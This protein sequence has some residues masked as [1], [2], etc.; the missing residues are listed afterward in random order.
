MGRLAA[1]SLAL[2]GH[3]VY[4]SMRGVGTRNRDKA[5]EMT[6]FARDNGVDLQPLELDVLSTESAQAA[7]RVVESEQARV[8]AL[9]NNAAHLYFGITDAFTPE[10]LMRGFDTNVLG[11]LRVHHAFLPMMR[12]QRSGLLLWVGS[13]STRVVPPFLGP[14]TAAKAAFDSYAES[15]SYE[16]IRFGIDTAIVMPGIFVDGTAHFP[17]AESPADQDTQAEY[18]ALYQPYLDRNEQASR[19]MTLPGLTPDVQAVADEVV[20]V[21]GLPA[22]Q[23][24]F[25]TTVDFTGVGD[26]PVNEAAATSRRQ[27]MERMGMSDLLPTGPDVVNGLRV[28][29]DERAQDDPA[30]TQQR[31]NNKRSRHEHLRQHHLHPR[32][33]AW[34]RPGLRQAARR[35][36]KSGRDRRASSA[37]D[38]ILRLPTASGCFA[39]SL[40]G[41]M[42]ASRASTPC[43][44]RSAPSSPR[45]SG[46]ATSQLKQ[47]AATRTYH[48][49]H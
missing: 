35:G 16:T 3:T 14:Y 33:D 25:R 26:I 23:R 18:L 44:T 2:A 6:Q 12:A 28:S 9:V 34:H 17:N 8:D 46:S 24:P 39:A 38:R 20:R 37:P 40:T 11:A 32:R 36:R 1:R 30:G 4:A 43:S 5:D 15:V 42:P 19:G 7:A 21:V 27:F 13:G 10:Q 31:P 47:F 49:P 41:H 48:D 45:G 29:A 22:G